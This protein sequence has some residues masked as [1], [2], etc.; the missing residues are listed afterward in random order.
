MTSTP[1]CTISDYGDR[2][3]VQSC[4]LSGLPDLHT[5]KSD[6]QTELRSY[7]QAL[8]NAGVKGF[9]IDGA[10]HMSAQDI[11][12]ILNGLT[13]DFYVFQEVIDQSSSERVR[14]WEYAPSGDVTEFAYAFALGAAFDDACGGSLS[15]L[16]NRFSQSDMLP[17]RFAQV[18]TDNHDNQRGHGVGAGCVVDHRDGQ[19]HVLANIFAL[20][21]PYGYPSVMS[22]FYWQSSSTDNTGDSMGPPSTNDG[23]TTW[24]VGLGAVTRPVYGA[25]PGRGRQSR[26]TARQPTRTANGPASIAAR[27][28]PTWCVPPGDGGRSGQQLAEHR[29]GD[30][31]PHRVRPRSKGFVAIN[32]TGSQRH[33]DLRHQ[34]ARR[35]LLRHHEVRLPAGHWAVRLSRDDQPGSGR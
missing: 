27:R 13:G 25:G 29:R 10:K 20:A 19:E 22:S 17:S 4:K 18:F 7:L 16:Q 33:D 24:G 28:P 34:H 21:Y 30:L 14:D 5:G 15:D 9:R 31:R 2:A 12:A 35:R 8:I 32:R 26:P 1:D 11:A 23:G 3:Q 6:V